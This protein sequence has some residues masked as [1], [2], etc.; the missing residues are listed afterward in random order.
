MKK[1]LV[2]CIYVLVSMN[3]NRLE[4]AVNNITSNQIL[5]STG[6]TIKYSAS[7]RITLTDGF[8]VTNNTRFKTYLNGCGT[9]VVD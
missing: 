3:V 8:S 2:F 7:N 6:N 5:N 4:E 9:Q 1:R